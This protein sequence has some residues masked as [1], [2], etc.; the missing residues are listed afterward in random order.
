M[1]FRSM[2]KSF[3]ILLQNIKPSTSLEHF[4]DYFAKITG[5]SNRTDMF[6]DP[7]FMRNCYAFTAAVD[8]SA[9]NRNNASH[10]GTFISIEQ[11]KSDKKTVLSELESVRSDSLG[12]I[13]Q[14]IFLLKK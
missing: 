7:D 6:N 9:D 5:Y 8:A 13:Q 4:C 11:C 1:L 14:L 2:Y 12:L 3:A 10:G